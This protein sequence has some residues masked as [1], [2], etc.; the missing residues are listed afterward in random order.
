M[1]ALQTIPSR[2]QKDNPQNERKYLQNVSLDLYPRNIK[3]SYESIKKTN[4][5]FPLWHNEIGGVSEVPGHRLD[6]QP[7]TVG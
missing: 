2:K 7:S 5:E 4:E 1:F 6:P 3:N